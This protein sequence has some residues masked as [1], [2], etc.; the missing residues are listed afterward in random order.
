MAEFEKQK[1]NAQKIKWALV[2]DKT[3]K[4]GKKGKTGKEKTGERNEKQ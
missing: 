2:K 1:Q 3:S 4:R